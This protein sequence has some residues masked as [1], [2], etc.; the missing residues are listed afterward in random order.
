MI[1][2]PVSYGSDFLGLFVKAYKDSDVTKKLT[3][4]E[5]IDECKTFYLAGHETTAS[6]LT[7]TVLLLTIHPDWQEKVRKEAL[8]L[9]GRQNRKP[10]SLG[11]LKI[12]G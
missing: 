5:M 1:T 2:E 6:S 10:D 12:V 7:W 8:Q 3:I 4:D 11:K 9:F